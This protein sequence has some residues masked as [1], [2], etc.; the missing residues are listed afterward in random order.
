MLTAARLVAVPI[1]VVLM[2]A[3]AG[4]HGPARWWVLAVFLA[5]A[6]T[7]FLDGYFARRWKVVSEFGKLADPIAD[8]ALVLTTLLMV[9]IVDGV[10]WWPLAV[11]AVREVGIT[12]GRLAVASEAVIPASAGGKLKTTLQLVAVT[13]FLVPHAPQWLT[14]AAWW[15][16]V[17]AVLVAIVTGLDYAAKIRRVRRAARTPLPVEGQE[18]SEPDAAQ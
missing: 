11:L 8:K 1:I 6:A 7:D 4:A 16:L 14:A 9:V 12:L 2:I 3:D 15:C 10:A 18:N 17:A 13:L 5:A